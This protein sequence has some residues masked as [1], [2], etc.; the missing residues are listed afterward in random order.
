MIFLDFA[1]AFDKVP[2]QRLLC[3]LR[4]HGIHG[5]ILQWISAWL[6]NRRQR[7]CLLGELSGWLDVTSGV[8]QG[9]VLGPVLFL[10]FINDLD[11]GIANWILK[12]A[13]D[14]KIYGCL[15]DPIDCDTL[16]DDLDLLCTWSNEWQMQFNIDK[17]KV[18]HI[19]K[20]NPLCKYKMNGS[21]LEEV[22]IEKDLGVYISNDAKP[23][24]QCQQ[25]YLKANRMLGFV[26]R[27]IISR[28]PS[29]LLNLYKSFVRPHLEYCS[30]AWSPH[31]KKDKE[32]LERVQ[33]RF[34]RLFS[35]LRQLD[36]ITPLGWIYWGYGL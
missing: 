14:T 7:V 32:L 29:I 10:I 34:T 18:M 12:F 36:Y 4:A 33:H 17:C 8:P 6:M 35:H 15:K 19:G 26:K 27:N 24:V 20:K 9:S 25:S 16:Q 28:N 5:K 31:Y 30:P 21:K 2:H 3:K 13:D 22:T 1:K 11:C 23:S